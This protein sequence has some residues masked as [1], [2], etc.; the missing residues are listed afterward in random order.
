MSLTTEDREWMEFIR[1][2]IASHD[3]QLGELTDGLVT[4]R[5]AVEVVTSNVA[6][7]VDVSNRDEGLV[8]T[9]ARIIVEHEDRIKK[10][11]P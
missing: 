11:E 2:S 8:Q 10:L 4:L 9:L 1:Q 3:R 7:L 6:K 5:A